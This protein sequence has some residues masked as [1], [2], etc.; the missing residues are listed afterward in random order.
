MK[1]QSTL[2]GLVTIY[3]IIMLIRHI[4]QPRSAFRGGEAIG[5]RTGGSAYSGAAA[6]LMPDVA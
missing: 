6:D 1:T 3:L 4:V 2:I 5:G